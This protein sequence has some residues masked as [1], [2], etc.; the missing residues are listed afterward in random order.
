MLHDAPWRFIGTNH[1]H[2]YTRILYLV[3][4]YIHNPHMRWEIRDVDCEWFNEPPWKNQFGKNHLKNRSTLTVKVDDSEARPL[5]KLV[6]WSM[7]VYRSY[8]TIHVLFHVVVGPAFNLGFRLE[9]RNA[10]KSVRKWR[11]VS[12]AS[13]ALWGIGIKRVE[14]VKFLCW[15]CRLSNGD[16]RFWPGFAP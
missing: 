2:T 7:K 4:T 14:R 9:R 16:V 8:W 12:R 10:G 11:A 3:T 13:A 6:L 5:S 15:P 1:F